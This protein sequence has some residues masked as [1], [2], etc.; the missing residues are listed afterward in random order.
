MVVVGLPPPPGPFLPPSPTKPFIRPQRL[1]W[2]N[3]LRLLMAS[4]HVYYH[5]YN[6]LIKN[7]IDGSFN[8]TRYRAVFFPLG[9]NQVSL[10]QLSLARAVFLLAACIQQ[11]RS[12]PAGLWAPLQ[13]AIQK[14][15]FYL[16]NIYLKHIYHRCPL[17][18]P[19]QMLDCHHCH[20]RNIVVKYWR[21]NNVPSRSIKN[22]WWHCRWHELMN[23]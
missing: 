8:S 4:A 17:L 1:N 15:H 2:F 5:F 21:Q 11:W 18:R 20:W 6:H 9:S 3:S 12:A 19:P 22:A 13:P 7:V 23:G 10:I 14:K 16:K